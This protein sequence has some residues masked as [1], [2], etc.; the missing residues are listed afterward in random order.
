MLDDVI[1]KKSFLAPA[2]LFAA[3]ERWRKAQPGKFTLSHAVRALIEIAL[4]K[5]GVKI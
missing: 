5:E 3:V 1:L 4:K 2:K